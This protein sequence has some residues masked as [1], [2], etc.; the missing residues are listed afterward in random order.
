[1]VG[2]DLL[3]R[4]EPA[5]VIEDPAFLASSPSVT[6]ALKHA[7]LGIAIFDSSAC[8]IWRPRGSI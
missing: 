7:P 8:A 5:P 4:R 2:Q 6:T 1:M 3:T